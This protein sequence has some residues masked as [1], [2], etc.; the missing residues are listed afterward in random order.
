M[1]RLKE[2][3][4]MTPEKQVVEKA[5]IEIM[6]IADSLDS[7]NIDKLATDLWNLESKASALRSFILA[8]IIRMAQDQPPMNEFP[9]LHNEQALN[10][11]RKRSPLW[12]HRG[13]GPIALHFPRKIG[14]TCASNQG[15]W[16][17]SL[18][19]LWG[20]TASTQQTNRQTT[21]SYHGYRDSAF[22]WFHLV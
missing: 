11:F 12:R 13:T 21:Q 1:E 19:V 9:I 10:Y 6:D 14:N 20:R 2:R 15:T 16:F 8:H 7:T 17:R 4:N 5:I 22:H 3:M 18:A